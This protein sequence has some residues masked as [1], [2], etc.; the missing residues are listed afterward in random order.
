MIIIRASGASGGGAGVDLTTNLVARLLFT[1]DANDSVGSY[2]ATFTGSSI[3]YDANDGIYLDRTANHKVRFGS[4]GGAN[5][6]STVLNDLSSNTG[7][8]SFWIKPRVTY[9]AGSAADNV[10]IFGSYRGGSSGQ[11]GA[12][13]GYFDQNSVVDAGTGGFHFWSKVLTGDYEGADWQGDSGTDWVHIVLTVDGTDVKMYKDGSLADSYTASSG[14]PIDDDLE[15]EINGLAG[16][17]NTSLRFDGWFKD[18]SVW[19]GRVLNA[20]EV[21]SLNTTGHGGSY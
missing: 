14:W 9:V 17:A 7:T 20:T 11:A 19:S 6:L 2:D 10:Y 5:H 21:G 4:D 12:H 13:F 18:L 8:I 15:W 1:S 3:T 16:S